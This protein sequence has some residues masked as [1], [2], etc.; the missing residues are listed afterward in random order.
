MRRLLFALLLVIPTLT[1]AQELPW[2]IL[3]GG[4]AQHEDTEAETNFFKFG[5]GIPAYDGRPVG[6][7][8]AYWQFNEN[9]GQ[10]EKKALSLELMPR[11]DLGDLRLFI[12]GGPTVTAS[13]TGWTY[14]GGLEYPLFRASGYQW[15]LRLD[16]ERFTESGG[17]VEDGAIEAPTVGLIVAH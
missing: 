1:H 6:V 8:L 9:I 4:K 2:L 11:L 17:L 13:A 7:E 10:A 5:F 15:K 3:G 14:G 16:W 12:R